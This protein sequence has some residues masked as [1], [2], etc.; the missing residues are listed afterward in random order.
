MTNARSRIELDEQ[1][2]RELLEGA[3]TLQVASLGADGRPHL[4]PMWFAEDDE[5][6]LAFTTYGKSQ[7]V[8]N[9]ERDPRITVLAETGTAYNEVRGL[10]IDGTAEVVHDPAV[11][12]RL[13]QLVGAR[14]AGRPRPEFDP[15][16]EPPAAAY[17]RE[18]GRAHV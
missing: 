15:K 4:V 14:Q 9:L 12:A 8:V 17:K 10:S 3:A 18:I 5:G 7:K 16:L 6:L 13:L 1:E 2:R 11:T